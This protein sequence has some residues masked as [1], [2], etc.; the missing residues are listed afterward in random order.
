MMTRPMFL[1]ALFTL[2]VL[3]AIISRAFA[4]PGPLD[5]AHKDLVRIYS[6][7]VRYQT[8]YDRGMPYVRTW[9][10]Y[11]ALGETNAWKLYLRTLVRYNG[12]KIKTASRTDQKAFW[13]NTYNS[14]VIKGVIES[15]P[16]RP[17][18][19][20]PAGSV[21]SVPDFFTRTHPVA[22][23]MVSLTQIEQIL[24]GFDDPRVWFAL[25]QGTVGSPALPASVCNPTKLEDQLDAAVGNFLADPVRFRIERDRNVIVLASLFQE[26]ADAFATAGLTIP[27]ALQS[28]PESQRAILAF[29]L[30]RIR[31]QD[32]DYILEFKPAVRFEPADWALNLA[33]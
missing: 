26:R 23:Q 7:F 24:S 1:R 8:L 3:G 4:V 17:E 18:P 28:Y 31:P 33:E 16:L 12:S 10:K 15:W 13:I 2:A 9:I 21:R 20:Q 25:C 11:P 19:G 30:P 22:G 14:L 29:I 5:D 6:G 27:E 32:R